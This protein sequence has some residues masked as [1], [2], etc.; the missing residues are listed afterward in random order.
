MIEQ[1]STS[2]KYKKSGV[3]EKNGPL[4]SICEVDDEVLLSSSKEF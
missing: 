3:I 4:I 2:K 1:S